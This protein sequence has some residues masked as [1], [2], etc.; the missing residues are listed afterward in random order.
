MEELDEDNI[1]TFDHD[2]SQLNLPARHVMEHL[3]QLVLVK[4]HL[5][6]QP[7]A[8]WTEEDFECNCAAHTRPDDLF[9]GQST[10]VVTTA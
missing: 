1:P 4:V 6:R 2:R 3:A 5:S 8:P 10:M 7:A 9:L